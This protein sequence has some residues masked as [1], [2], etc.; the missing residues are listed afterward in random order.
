MPPE[1]LK[2]ETRPQ[3]LPAKKL[4]ALCLSCVHILLDSDT[5]QGRLVPYESDEDFRKLRDQ[6][7]VF[8]YRVR[9]SSASTQVLLV[10]LGSPCPDTTELAVQDYIS[11]VAR[12][13]ER[14]LISGLPGLE[15]RP[16]RHGL[17]RIRRKDDLI[18]SALSRLRMDRPK[19]L[20]GFHKFHRTVFR[21]RHEFLASRGKT[22]ML[23]VD[24][25]R[26]QEISPTLFELHERGLNLHGLEVYERKQDGGKNW[27]GK[28][29]G[30]KDKKFILD[31]DGGE[32][33]TDGTTVWLEPSTEAF[34]VLFE[35]A[36]GRELYERMVR[37]E[38]A[39]RADEV[40]GGG[41]V[42]RLQQVTEYLQAAEPISLTPMLR[43]KFG[44]IVGLARQ[45]KRVD[46]TQMPAVDYVFSPDR[47]AVHQYPSKGL[48]QHGP[49]DGSYFDTKEPHV[50][51]VCPAECQSSV[52]AFVRNLRDGTGD[53]ANGAFR[54][55]LVGTYRLHRISVRF[56][57]V[58]LS[59][60]RMNVGSRY[61]ASLRSELSSQRAPDIVLVI[62]RDEDAFVE[63]DNPYL[64]AKA[65]LLRQGIP[66]QEV[67]L[68]NVRSSKQELPYKLRDMAVAMY[69]KLGGSPWTVHPTTPLVR[70]V[71]IGMAHAEFGNRHSPRT[72][73]MG[74][75]T[76]FS[77]N[78]TYLLAGG[79]PRCLYDDYPQELTRSVRAILLRLAADY[80][81]SS[82]D[83]VR[84]VFHTTKP[85]TGKEV[86][87]LAD[88][89]V[90]C[91]GKNI[92][93]QTAFLTIESMHPYLVVAP[94]EQGRKAFVELFNGT[95]GQ[96]TV[97]VCAPTRGLMID[98]GRS[99]R[100]LCLN[101]P[102]LMKREGES[103]PRPIQIDLHPRSTY[104]DMF[105]LTRQVF[106]FTGLSWRSMLP[107]TEPVT[108][109]YPYLIAKM[110][111][112]FSALTDWSDDLLDTRLSR[113]RWFL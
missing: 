2:R 107:V 45:G 33:L 91:L 56:L 26:H 15:L 43:M 27:L 62:I 79:T 66:S 46:A 78:G 93:V 67:R 18:D 70:E 8:A 104:T 68:S 97:G 85:L 72:R 54:R 106:H 21:V 30:L 108:I 9:G 20:A 98:L 39:Q 55:G 88:N 63:S 111:G 92:Q 29:V 110:L 6:T 76:V 10:P 100:L 87:M 49:M 24:F 36:L 101:G 37:A 80:G 32:L 23:T 22:L 113:S 44:D 47:T 75:T 84:L 53:L 7:D 99:K 1:A 90:S 83:I 38:W 35:Q 13:I 12:L 19:K 51:V 25:R 5:I 3:R 57:P 28:V 96:A 60:V 77:G 48:E 50:L 109:Y 112:R 74:I 86:D 17:E 41:Y 40:C 16:T 82:G 105:A 34:R 89:A 11:A 69:A 65:Y 31:L 103:I 14:Q 102:L 94:Y 52:E 42:K 71:V 59:G 61:V 64:A 81:W 4:P 95:R 58:P 73:Y